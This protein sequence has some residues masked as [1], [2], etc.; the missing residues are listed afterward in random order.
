MG[1]VRGHSEIQSLGTPTKLTLLA[2]HHASASSPSTGA[3]LAAA[4]AA[5]LILACAAWGAARWW[6]YEPH[7]LLNARHACAE[8]GMRLSATWGELGD[9]MRL[10]R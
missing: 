8:A 10:G 7:W 4:L 1:T 6:A 2:A 9:W 5:L 3:L